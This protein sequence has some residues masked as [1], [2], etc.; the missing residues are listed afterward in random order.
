MQNYYFDYRFSTNSGDILDQIFKAMEK[1]KA[2]A[3]RCDINEK[4]IFFL[5]L[6]TEES[7]YNAY[8]YCKE[9]Q[10]QYFS[11]SWTIN[12]KSLILTVYHEGELFEVKINE[13]VNLGSRGRGL[14]LISNL[15]DDV[16]VRMKENIVQLVMIKHLI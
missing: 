10:K 6:V 15:M 4:E 9:N 5:Q 11:F 14:Q 8:E 16:Q 7:C 3:K 2:L 12:E 13:A 1:T